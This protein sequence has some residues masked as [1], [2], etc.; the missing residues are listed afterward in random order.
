MKT[1]LGVIAGA[2]VLALAIPARCQ[3]VGESR[4]G[5]NAIAFRDI[6]VIPMDTERVLP[7]QTVVV[8]NGKIVEIGPATLCRV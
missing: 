8:R 3:S 2:V 1:R 7:D 5:N 6:S 4:S